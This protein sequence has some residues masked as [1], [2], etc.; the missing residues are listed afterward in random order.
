MRAQTGIIGTTLEWALNERGL[1]L[2]HYPASA[3]CATLGGYLAAR[4]SGV[5]STKYGKAEDLVLT[6]EVVLPDGDDRADAAGAQPRQRAPACCSCSSAPR[7]R[8]A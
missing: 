8:S 6:L 2:P 7:A 3:N 1:T 5:I 4:G